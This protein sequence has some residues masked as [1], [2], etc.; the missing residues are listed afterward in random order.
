MLVVDLPNILSAVLEKEEMGS[1]NYIIA[2]YII[3][4]FS[5]LENISTT[6]LAN[7]C[8]VSKSSISRF[9]RKVGLEDFFSLK[10]LIMNYSP[11][12]T[13]STKYNFTKT[14]GDDISD[15]INEYANKIERIENTLDRKALHELTND[16]HR[17]ENVYLMGMQQSGGI[18]MAL[19]NDLV[20]FNTYVS[21]I[22][23]PKK[24]KEILLTSTSKDLI[25]VFSAT[26]SFFEKVV[27][28]IQNMKRSEMPR[29]YVITVNQKEIK[30]YVYKQISLDDKYNFASNLLLNFYA[31]LIAIDY[32]SKFR[33]S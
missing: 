6:Q 2:D 26:G 14:S 4:N 7:A 22:I 29:I 9:C 16:I 23:E 33:V 30:D 8:N 11:E 1:T 3:K 24:Q 19:Q 28:R 5:H 10:V 21:P 32:K 18:I 13:I 20:S 12:R 25:I 27:P 17:Y 15:F 31:S